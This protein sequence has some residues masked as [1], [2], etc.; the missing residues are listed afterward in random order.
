MKR[1][2]AMS[3][4]LMILSVLIGIS[5]GSYISIILSELFPVVFSISGFVV[6]V[7][8][9]FYLSRKFVDRR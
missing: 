7:A 2:T 5:A 8:L 6:F 1:L 4:L 9:C 3:L